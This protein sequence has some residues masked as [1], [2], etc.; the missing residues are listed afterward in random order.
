VK[1]VKRR[2]AA[3]WFLTHIRDVRLQ[4]CADEEEHRSARAGQRKDIDVRGAGSGGVVKI[5]TMRER[6]F[7]N[8]NVTADGGR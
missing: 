8:Q 2:R 1:D 3:T 4:V 6:E 5:T 7:H